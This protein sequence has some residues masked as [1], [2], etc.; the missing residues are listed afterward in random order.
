MAIFADRTYGEPCDRSFSAL[1]VSA[2]KGA[3]AYLASE[4]AQLQPTLMMDPDDYFP[5][6]RK[7][8]DLFLTSYMTHLFFAQRRSVKSAAEL[9]QQNDAQCTVAAL[10]ADRKVIPASCVVQH[11]GL[12][13]DSSL[14]DKLSTTAPCL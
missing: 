9:Q 6:L 4:A 8:A 13:W 11:A 3:A 12:L 14:F 2:A 5:T 7:A 10:E 1:S